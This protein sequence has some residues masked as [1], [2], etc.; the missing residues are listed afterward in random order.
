MEPNEDLANDKTAKLETNPHLSGENQHVAVLR[1]TD[2]Q[3]LKQGICIVAEAPILYIYF[4][5]QV[6]FG[7]WLPS[8]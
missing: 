2:L 7:G 1:K 3:Q 4:Y 6:F 5:F 8:N